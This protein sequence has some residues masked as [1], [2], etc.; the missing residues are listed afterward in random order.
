MTY[1]YIEAKSNYH[2]G[3]ILVLRC[4]ALEPCPPRTP[5]DPTPNS[6]LVLAAG[7][8][9]APKTDIDTDDIGLISRALMSLKLF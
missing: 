3:S 2:R 5:T 9:Y 1:T 4:V 7:F 8:Y 6:Y